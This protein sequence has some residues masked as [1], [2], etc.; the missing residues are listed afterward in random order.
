MPLIPFITEGVEVNSGSTNQLP[1]SDMKRSYCSA[2]I[3][4][5][6]LP[7]ESSLTR[8]SLALRIRQNAQGRKIKE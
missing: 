4:D 6:W 2:G 8:I 1:E 7:I 5:V 3:K